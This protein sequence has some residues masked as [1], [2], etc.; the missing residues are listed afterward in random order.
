[1]FHYVLKCIFWVLQ[2]W[3]FGNCTCHYNSYVIFEI[4]YI[5]HELGIFVECHFKRMPI[6][7]C[8]LQSSIRRNQNNFHLLNFRSYFDLY[9]W[10]DNLDD[11][12]PSI[13]ISSAVQKSPI[14][15]F[16]KVREES[17]GLLTT[18]LCNGGVFCCDLTIIV[19]HNEI[20][21][22]RSKVVN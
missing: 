8:P 10:V 13:S 7:G 15:T 17:C 20:V 3:R 5:T 9:N 6:S 11:N 4:V 1:M 14:L 19:L 2:S 16:V 21:I 12:S 18:N 22:T